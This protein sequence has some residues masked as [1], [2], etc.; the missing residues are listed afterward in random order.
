MLTKR[1]TAVATAVAIVVMLLQPGARADAE[2]RT[3]RAMTDTARW[4]GEFVA[5][6][7][8]TWPGGP[9][10]CAD[11]AVCDR[12]DVTLDLPA[13]NWTTPGG[14]LVSIQWPQFDAGHDLDLYVYGPDGS[15]VARS[16]GLVFSQTEAAWIP[17]PVNGVYAIVVAPKDVVAQPV[18]PDI[19]E[20]LE[21]E[22]IAQLQRGLTVSRN[23]LNNGL[24]FSPTFVALG[25]ASAEPVEEF[26]PDLKPTTPT[27]FHVE[28][29]VGAHTYF[30][31]DRGLR[32][33]PSCYPQETLG[34]MSDTPEPGR[35]PQRCLRW[36]QGETNLGPG[37]LEL[38]NYPNRGNGTEVFQRLYHSDGSVRQVQIPGSIKFSQ[39]HGHVHYFG[40]QTVTLRARRA[41]G[42]PGA[43]VRS[44]GDK[45]ICMVDIRND[46]FGTSRGQPHMYSV[47]GTCDAAT[48]Q[49]PNDPTYPNEGFFQLGISPGYADIY[50]WFIGD[51]FLDIT[52][53]ADGMYVMVVEQNISGGI[54]ESDYTNNTASACIAITSDSASAC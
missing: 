13:D 53:L 38:H 7:L 22:G 32:H 36:D 35:G 46:W 18:V 28:S 45:G 54:I 12:I 34:L 44:G 40:F 50:P 51:Q 15:Q 49:D 14:L 20:P 47:P 24:R 27:N 10:I 2:A 4:S 11:R 3:L 37:P 41:D 5:G 9:E 17:Q 1:I 33:Q 39:A 52:G 6:A 29:T 26:L 42:T 19:L 23:E 8:A 30:Y 21:Y 31:A 43:A 16:D 48:R 25:R